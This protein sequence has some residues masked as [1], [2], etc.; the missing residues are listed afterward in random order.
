[1]TVLLHVSAFIGGLGRHLTKRNNSG[2][3]AIWYNKVCKINQMTPKH[4]TN[5]IK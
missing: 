4:I 1:M 5:K 2:N 3:A